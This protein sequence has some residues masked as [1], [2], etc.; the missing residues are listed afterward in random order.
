MDDFF[1]D[2]TLYCG[3]S[4]VSRSDVEERVYDTLDSLSISYMRVD[5]G[6]AA[7]IDK[8]LAVENVLGADIV[9]NLFLCNTQKTKFYMLIMPGGKVFKTKDLSKQIGSARLSFGDAETMERLLGV[10]PGSMS[11]FGLLNDAENEVRLLV[12]R[13][14]LESEY[15]GFHPCKNTSTLKISTHDMF[16]VFVP[17]IK[18]EPIFVELPEYNV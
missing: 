6:E 14:V 13:D 4:A 12:D 18:R 15:I 11:I 9:K 10:T 16:D 17:H 8:C 1:V 7:T 2:K 3:R 5:H